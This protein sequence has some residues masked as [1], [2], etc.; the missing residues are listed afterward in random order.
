MI[1]QRQAWN[2]VLV[3]EP[4]ITKSLAPTCFLFVLIFLCFQAA[5]RKLKTEGA[6]ETAKLENHL[7][8]ERVRAPRRTLRTRNLKTNMLSL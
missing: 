8:K 4:P 6:R 1:Y 5:R 2:L 3:L 7:K